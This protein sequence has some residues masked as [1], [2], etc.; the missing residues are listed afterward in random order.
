MPGE[1]VYDTIP[2]YRLNSQKVLAYLQSQWPGYDFDL[3][4]SQQEMQR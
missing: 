1:W 4:V 3:E 2:H